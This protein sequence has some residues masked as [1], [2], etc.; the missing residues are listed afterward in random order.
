MSG[1]VDAGCWPGDDGRYVTTH[2]PTF[3]VVPRGQTKHV[4]I[5]LTERAT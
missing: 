5:T 2:E 4:T 1:M 3:R